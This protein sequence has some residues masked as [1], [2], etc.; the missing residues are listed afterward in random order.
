M[1]KQ[2]AEELGSGTQSCETRTKGLQE[3]GRLNP[4][5]APPIIFVF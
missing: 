3:R 1:N 4:E 2:V 5:S